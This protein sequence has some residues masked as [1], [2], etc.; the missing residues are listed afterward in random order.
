MDSSGE[1]GNFAELKKEYKVGALAAGKP[2]IRFY[3]NEIKG[4]LK[5]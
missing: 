5:S 4:N 3:P 1:N 2:V